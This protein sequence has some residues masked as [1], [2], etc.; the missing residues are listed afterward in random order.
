MTFSVLLPILVLLGAAWGLRNDLMYRRLS[1]VR[2]AGWNL[3]VFLDVASMV[4]VCGVS[5]GLVYALIEAAFSERALPLFSPIP[6][7]SIAIVVVLVF[8]TKERRR[9]IQ[10]QRPAGIAFGETLILG[11][12]YLLIESAVFAS[13]TW[14]RVPHGASAR[15]EFAGAIVI[16]GVIIAIVV[17]PFIRGFEGHRILE[18]VAE[19]GESVQPE[20][21]P[22]TWECPH[23]E[24]W[25]MVDSQ[26]TE[27]EVIDFLKALV[28]AVKPQRIVETGTFLGYSTLKMA[29][30]LK[31]NGFGKIVTIEYD[32]RIFAKAKERIDAS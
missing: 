31:S 16:G 19:H 4:A 18:R 5:G 27:L 12:A 11:G 10:F 2:P 29:E 23:P 20:Y 7:G 25:K 3:L 13:S 14:P 1:L 32:P 21:T 8:L 22:P 24:R 28:I 30:G 17:P 15:V 6:S 9:Q 26:T